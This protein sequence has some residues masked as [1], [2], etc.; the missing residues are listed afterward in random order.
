[1][2]TTNDD[3]MAKRLPARR[4]VLAGVGFGLLSAQSG[5]AAESKEMP[6]RELGKTG[7]K[8]SCLGMGGSHIGK[9]KIT[10]DQA[11]RLIRQAI[12]RGLNFMDNCWDYNDGR[13]ETVMGNALRDGYRAK[14]FLMTKFDGRTKQEALK[15]IDES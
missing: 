7:Q 8:V 2:S 3:S 1:M 14:A 10:Q 9:P 5:T 6:Y 11:T 4:D 12:D 15:Q 13:S